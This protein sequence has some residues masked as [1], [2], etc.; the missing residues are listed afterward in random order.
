MQGE[1]WADGDGLYLSPTTFGGITNI[2]PTAPS[3]SVRLGY[4]VQASPNGSIFVKVDNGYELDELHNVL[5]NTSSLAYGDLL[6]RDGNNVWINT[7][8]L[9]GSYTITGSLTISGSSTFTNIGPAVF[10]GSIN[11]S[12]SVLAGGS[13]LPTVSSSFS[14]GSAENPW[15]DIFLKSG[16]ISIQSD[17]PGDPDTILSNK[18]GNI[19]LSAGGMKLLGSG[20]F[21]ATTGSFSYISGS[22]T[23][24]GTFNQ[25][26]NT[27]IT[28]S[29]TVSGAATFND[30]FYYNGHQ[31]FNYGQFSS[32]TSQS[33]SVNV[34][35]SFN[36]DTTVYS[37]GVSVVSGSRI[38]L[39]HGGIYNITATTTVNITTNVTTNV[40]L[41]LRK[42][43]SNIANSTVFFQGRAVYHY[44][45][46]NHVVSASAGDYFEVMK[47]YDADAPIFPAIAAAGSVPAVPSIIVTVTQIA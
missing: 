17:V 30:G 42:N 25:V 28:G 35:S 22:L 9:S 15:K 20:S 7:K 29:L 12:G 37:Q 1:T 47:M 26:G 4:V 38:T 2:P 44:L 21:I 46:L 45:A 34:T 23:H 16:S 32:T 19:E 33:G 36:Y 41:W 11:I 8:N 5:I 6:M 40:Y 31:M 24:V 13:I 18:G 3:H 27:T 14:L 10:S 39:T 43:E